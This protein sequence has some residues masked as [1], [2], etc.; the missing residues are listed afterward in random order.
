MSD[1]P[2][3]RGNTRWD[4]LAWIP[5][6]MPTHCL[7]DGCVHRPKDGA[8]R[9]EDGPT[10]RFAVRGTD[11]C[12]WHHARFPSV[13]ADLDSLI[14]DLEQAAYTRPK[15]GGDSS[16]TR[17]ATGGTPADVGT[18]WNPHAAA[19]LAEVGGWATYLVRILT[20]EYPDPIGITVQDSTRTK[21]RT[22]ATWY[23]SWLSRY[24]LIGHVLLEDAIRHRRNGVRAL[25][26]EVVRRVTLAKA[27]CQHVIDEH[28]VYGSMVCG[29][30]LYGVLRPKD[31]GRPSEVLCSTNPNHPQL[32]RTSW[33]DAIPRTR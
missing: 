2:T 9:D 27:T 17:G 21:L 6:T 24:P 18:A 29:A 20:L 1:Y 14:R 19:V 13:L 7:A 15:T 30:P 33:V 31:E 12:N 5:E 23:S 25:Q 26:S 11:L 16:G 3:W 10:A 32:P 22:I 8:P 28:P 4:G